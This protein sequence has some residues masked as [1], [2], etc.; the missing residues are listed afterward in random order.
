MLLTTDKNNE[1]PF[2]SYWN[3]FADMFFHHSSGV[4]AI[5]MASPMI[6]HQKFGIFQIVSEFSANTNID[7]WSVNTWWYNYA[8]RWAI[9]IQKA[10]GFVLLWPILRIFFDWH[11]KT[12]STIEI[13]SKNEL[14]ENS[15]KRHDFL[16]TNDDDDNGW[17]L[18]RSAQRPRWAGYCS[19]WCAF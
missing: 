18:N 15:S 2:E 10:Y 7:G 8:E 11:A 5:K 16:E 9:K 14:R 4:E 13:D 3:R 1:K 12:H 17:N 19:I 6:W